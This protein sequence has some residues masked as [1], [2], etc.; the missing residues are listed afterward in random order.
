MFNDPGVPRLLLAE[1]T[2]I[3]QDKPNTLL[4]T[5]AGGYLSRKFS[6]P[7][8]FARFSQERII[9][10]VVVQKSKCVLSVTVTI[11]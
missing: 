1:F 8:R 9:I 6:T 5:V 10:V 2:R 4:V 7:K 11:C 3:Y